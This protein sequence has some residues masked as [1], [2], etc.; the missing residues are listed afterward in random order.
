MFQSI[1]PLKCWSRPVSCG[2]LFVFVALAVFATACNSNSGGTIVIATPTAT[3]TPTATTTPTATATPTVLS[4]VGVVISGSLPIGNA[5]VTLYAAGT[6][7]YGSTPTVLA[8]TTTDGGGN[9]NIPSF[10]CPAPAAQVYAVATGGNTVAA[11]GPNSAIALM[12][13]L[14]SCANFIGEVNIDEVTTIA[15]VY[16]LAQFMNPSNPRQ[17][18]TV[19]RY[20]VGLANAASTVPNLANLDLGV[21]AAFLSTGLN[22]PRTLNSLADII[23]PCVD[24]SG[25]LSAQC[26]VLFAPAT[27]PGGPAPT[28]TLA[29]ALDIA[30]NPVNNAALLFELQPAIPFAPYQ[31]ALGSAPTAW[32]LSLNYTGGGLDQPSGIAVDYFGNVW[33]SNLGNDSVTKLAPNGAPVSPSSGF[34][35]GG[36]SLGSQPSGVAI[37]SAH[38]AW[39]ANFG[40]DSVTELFLEGAPIS[41]DTGF[42]GGGLSRPTAIAETGDRAWIAN[43]S[44]SVTVLDVNGHPTSPGSGF[45]GAGLGVPNAIAIGDGSAWIANLPAFADPFGNI[46]EL[47]N[48]GAPISPSSG[49]VGG[50]V[51]EPVAIAVDPQGNAW[52]ANF[53]GNSITEL[54]PAGTPL[55]PSSGFVGGL[56]RPFGIA[57]DSAG[58]AWAAN[59]G[60]DSVTELRSSGM[61][62]SPATGFAGS[63]LANPHSMALDGSGNIWI[64]NVN[65]NTVTELIGLASP[66]AP[67]LV[68]PPFKP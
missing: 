42:T 4:F 23:A 10:T 60:N 9:F 68:G 46:T 5:T 34:V 15:S 11:A 56:N 16:A 41:P 25:P 22:S 49:F 26:K 7:G 52:V 58:N 24:S 30:L 12:A 66:I 31:P 61:P 29:A 40:N 48:L 36:L 28:N 59:S 62:L 18:G 13:A 55:S 2:L 6:T 33:T 57:V 14:N 1:P 8:E 65:N 67:P 47:S 53:S 39:V 50:G 3:P 64:A 17:I 32:T 51:N 63:G 19:A 21:A 54:S 43:L 20:P 35:G 37:D 27:P 38:N 44:G 45:T